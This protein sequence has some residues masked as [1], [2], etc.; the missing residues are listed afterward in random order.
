[1]NFSASHAVLQ[2]CLDSRLLAGVSALVLKNGE[3]VDKICIGKANLDTGEA[4][5]PDHI[6]R[7]YSSTKLITSVI[8][9]KLLDEGHFGLDDPI[10]RWIPEFGRVRVMRA[11]PGAPSLHRVDV[12]E[13]LQHD[14]SIRHLLSHQAGLS[15][16]VFDPGTPIFKAYHGA[17]VRLPSSSLAELMPMLAALPLLYQPGLGWEYSMATDVLARLVEIVTGQ[18]YGEALRTRLF[19]PLGMVDTSHLLRPDQ[20][21]RFVP[22]YRG[23]DLAQPVLPGLHPFPDVPWPDAFLKPVARQAGT[24]GLVITQADYL[25]LLLQLQ[26]GKPGFLKPATLAEMLRDQLPA[27]RSLQFSPDGLM[28]HIAPKLPFHMG[29]GL[30]GAVTRTRSP[31]QPNSLPGEFQW[32]GLAGTHWCISPANG[33]TIVLMAQRHFSF[34][35]PF[36]FDYKAAVYAAINPT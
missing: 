35:H 13:D 34:W 27:E 8:V 22:L 17:G 31:L 25:R 28:A 12:L 16:G 9:L 30:G 29:F 14:I 20:V 18:T 32:G 4:L 36:W 23:E 21:A 3:V 11:S 26:P 19:E 5:R 10:K 33:V 1:M 15:H 7:A 6:Y 24:S 2:S